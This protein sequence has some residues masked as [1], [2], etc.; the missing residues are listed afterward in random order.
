MNSQKTMPLISIMISLL[1]I[2]NEKK[3]R[4]F[5]M[6]QIVSNVCALLN[7]DGGA[8]SLDYMKEATTRKPISE[9]IRMIEQR[10]YEAI[11]CSITYSKVKIQIL[12][13]SIGLDVEPS[14]S[15]VTLN[16]NL[17]IPNETQVIPVPSSEPFGKVKEIIRDR[18]SC[19]DVT[20]L[21][22]HC[23]EFIKGQNVKILE[24]KSVSFKCL[25]SCPSKNVTLAD[26][27]T[28]R[29]N[30][31]VFL[32]SAF[33][34]HSGGHIYYGIKDEGVVEGEE[35]NDKDQDEIAKKVTKVINK[36]IWSGSQPQRGTDWDIFFVPV[37]NNHGDPVPFTF[38]IVISIALYT[39]GV[40]TE[41]PE[42]YYV[43]DGRVVK[44]S[45]FEWKTRISLVDQSKQEIPP[46]VPRCSWSSPH[47]QKIFSVVNGSLMT[48]INN[49]RWRE[50][51]RCARLAE[52][53]YHLLEGVKLITLSKRINA[54]YRMGLFSEA[55]QMLE[56]YQDLAKT[57]KDS[58]IFQ[59]CGVYL[60]SAMKRCQEDFEVSHKIATDALGDLEQIPVGLITASFYIQIAAM[61]TSFGIRQKGIDKERF[62]LV[63]E[64][65]TYY[66][67]GLEHLEANCN[68]P[69]K[70]T[71]DMKQ[72]AHIHL[73]M[74]NLECAS[75]DQGQRS[76]ASLSAAISSL[77]L[78]DQS[79]YSGNPLTAFRECQYLLALSNLYYRQAQIETVD[80][81]DDL[82]QQAMCYS[83]KAENLA[84]WNKFN[85]ILHCTKNYQ[86]LYTENMIINTYQNP[87]YSGF[88]T[89]INSEIGDLN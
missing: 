14:D 52:E 43:R 29:S 26:R 61:I 51:E 71:V 28:G 3:Y 46:T 78:V 10:L 77:Q 59:V 40:F 31:F 32:V 48:L 87:N 16:Y 11:G 88:L 55:E 44:V 13:M 74:L 49:G 53:K 47:Q 65:E 6:K 75:Q 30:K 89:K 69:P 7:S 68:D 5:T 72:K 70:A 76:R 25:K 18:K 58:K 15:F 22:S 81:K 20:V 41:E 1:R 82:L 54:A 60:R 64:A 36:I 39:G 12:P 63:Q 34:N 2:I 9:C 56:K 50:F 67:K 4:E 24:S 84:A 62:S 73:A 35:T 21:G 8:L 38:V 83:K 33:A 42:S 37:K 85:E 23:R 66:R 57:S 19:G 80:K 79:V 17:Y 45:F 27:I 86:A